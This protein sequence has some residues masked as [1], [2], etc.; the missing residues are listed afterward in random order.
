MNEVVATD[1]IGTPRPSSDLLTLEVQRGISRGRCESFHPG[2]ITIGRGKADFVLSAQDRVV[3]RGVHCRITGPEHESGV[4]HWRLRNEHRNKIFLR[5]EA[6]EAVLEEG[7]QALFRTPCSLEF[8]G[9][10]PSILIH[11]LNDAEISRT[12]TLL[13]RSWSGD[14]AARAELIEEHLPWI[15]G[16][17]RARLGAGLRRRVDSVDIMQDALIRVLDSGP[18]VVVSDPQK[19]RALMC[20][21]IENT[22]RDENDKQRAQ[23]R[24][25]QRERPIQRDS[26]ICLDPPQRVEEPASQIAMR[27]EQKEL[28][29]C[30]LSCLEDDREIL[31]LRELE[32][33]SFKEIGA[34]LGIAE[35]AAR[36][37]YNRALPKLRKTLERLRQGEIDESIGRD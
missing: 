11:S 20:V 12:R 18:K 37:R 36:M 17:V 3:G 22:L 35:D 34:V 14:K 29:L 16:V 15:R 9:G 10:G 5:S 2:E 7:D 21:I 8:L 6:I 33:K 27:D 13:T 30:A 25:I 19:F 23:K 4:L 32:G 31:E 1:E 26:M 28:V 24:D